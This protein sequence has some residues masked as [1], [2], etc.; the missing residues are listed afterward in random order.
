ML[1]HNLC[2]FF[3]VIPY[4]DQSRWQSYFHLQR[5]VGYQ[6]E[7]LNLY[8]KI[9]ANLADIQFNIWKY[10]RSEFHRDITSK[11]TV[12]FGTGC[13]GRILSNIGWRP[14]RI[15]SVSVNSGRTN[16]KDTRIT[17]NYS[18]HLP[19]R[20]IEIWES[21]CFMFRSIITLITQKCNDMFLPPSNLIVGNLRNQVR[22]CSRQN[23]EFKQS[24]MSSWNVCE[25]FEHLFRS[26]R[27]M[28]SMYDR[29]RLF[30]VL[31]LS[32][33]LSLKYSISNIHH[34]ISESKIYLLDYEIQITDDNTT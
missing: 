9:K 21:H 23:T 30:F 10:L 25:V 4:L 32:D 13:S 24:K 34:I 3:K 12:L 5:T 7:I 29:V 16:G 11:L 14:W 27:V 28:V 26:H 8:A 1:P 2:S 17:T 20:I 15:A 6:K 19:N 31:N 22:R 18:F 33:N